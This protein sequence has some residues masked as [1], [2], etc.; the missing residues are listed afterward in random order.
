MTTLNPAS[1]YSNLAQLNNTALNYTDI[2]SNIVENLI[3]S[4]LTDLS[5]NTYTPMVNALIQAV[6]SI[7]ASSGNSTFRALL[8]T[9]DGTVAYDSSKS[10]STNT[11]ANYVN[12]TIN[13]NHQGRPEI[14]VALL[15]NTGTGLSNRFSRSLR[16][17]LKYQA[18]RLGPSTQ[19]N[20]GTFR[21][22]LN[23]FT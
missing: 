12:G 20:L 7:K 9:D 6:N 1:N 21:V 13:E 5:A 8:A 17:T 11:Y 14:L 19:S 16:T 3:Q 23:D 18:T 22:S 4:F 15:G 2:S 10:D